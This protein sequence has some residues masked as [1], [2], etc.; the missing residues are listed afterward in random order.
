MCHKRKAPFKRPDSST[1]KMDMSPCSR[2]QMEKSFPKNVIKIKCGDI[3]R[4]VP[5]LTDELTYNELCFLVHRL[6]KDSLSGNLENLVIKY[7]DE[8]NDLVLLAEDW[9]VKNA[10]LL[11]GGLKITVCGM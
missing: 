11:P 4:R 3:I 6:F 8:D 5:I 1:E 10:A 2:N 9:D 7:L